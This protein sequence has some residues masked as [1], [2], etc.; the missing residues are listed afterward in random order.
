[1]EQNFN[2]Y[3]VNNAQNQVVN[4]NSTEN[5]LFKKLSF[6][7]LLLAVAFNFI[8]LAFN[9]MSATTS[10]SKSSL[11]GY[12]AITTPGAIDGSAEAYG[13]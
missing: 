9:L 13:Y 11:S 6:V 10:Y 12:G 1:M 2:N 7:I 8:T 3:G 4:N 5:S